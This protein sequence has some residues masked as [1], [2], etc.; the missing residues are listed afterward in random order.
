MEGLKV[1]GKK[2]KARV[3]K[4]QGNGGKRGRGKHG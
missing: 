4:G 2:G 1:G 3:E